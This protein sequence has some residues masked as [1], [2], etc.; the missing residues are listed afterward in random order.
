[1]SQD[2]IT[3]PLWPGGA[4]GALGTSAE[5]VPT[6]TAY[7]AQNPSGSAVVICPGGGYWRLAMDHEGE[8]VAR[9]FQSR[10]IHAFVLKYRLGQYG[11]RHPSM[12]LDGQRAMR[13]VRSIAAA[14]GID[15]GKVGIMGFSAGGHLASTVATHFDLGDSTASDPV[16]RYSCQ[17]N[18]CILGYPVISMLEPLVHEGSRNNLLGKEASFEL[19]YELSNENQVKPGTPPTFLVHTTA[20]QSVI[21]ENSIMYYLAL[22]R[23]EIPAELHIYQ[24]GRHG[25]GMSPAGDPVFSTWPERLQD[26]LSIHGWLQ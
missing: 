13:T 14:R 22:R 10:G 5:D 4:P 15:P 18:F 23:A 8:Q 6:L 17:P 9:W 12:M 3:T 24:E 25:L 21:P 16:D 26:W 20:D 1:M 11:Y 7:W 2:T 19:M